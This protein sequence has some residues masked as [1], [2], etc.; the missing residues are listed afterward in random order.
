MVTASSY[1]NIAAVYQKQGDYEKSL[2]WHIKALKIC[3]RIYATE[4]PETAKMYHNIGVNYHHKGE[5]D[6]ALDWLCRSLIVMSICGLADHPDV[7]AYGN[8]L[9]FCFEKSSE[10]HKDFVEWFR[11]RVETYPSWCSQHYR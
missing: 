8:S 6:K 1:N 7:D 3:E 11:E 5:H 9:G 4:H 2:E 10:S